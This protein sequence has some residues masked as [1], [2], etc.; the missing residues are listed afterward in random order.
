MRRWKRLFSSFPVS[1]MFLK[2]QQLLASIKSAQEI[3]KMNLCYDPVKVLI[4]LEHKINWLQS[5]SIS[6]DSLN[7]DTMYDLCSISNK[8]TI[9]ICYQVH[10]ILEH[11][12]IWIFTYKFFLSKVFANLCSLSLISAAGRGSIRP[13][14]SQYPHHFLGH[15]L[16]I[17][18]SNK[19]QVAV[20]FSMMEISTEPLSLTTKKQSKVFTLHYWLLL[21][22][23]W[24]I[25]ELLHKF[26]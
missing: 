25:S 11:T 21:L 14:V 7:Y 3:D 4:L 10:T 13:A 16:E 19:A 12:Q 17:F 2:Q 9:S 26:P 8:N 18:S 24:D 5:F 20:S 15:H 23:H 1:Y 6:L 22:S